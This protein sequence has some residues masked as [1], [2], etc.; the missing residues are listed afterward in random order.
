M[1]MTVTTGGRALTTA[2]ALFVLFSVSNSAMDDRAAPALGL[3]R[4]DGSIVQLADYRGK[5]V[6]VDFWASWCVPCKA[7]FPALD[8]LYQ[9][10]RDRGLEV[11]AVNVDEQRKAADAFLA[12]RPHLMPVLFDPKGE[13][14]QAFKIQGMP[15]SILIDRSGHIRFTHMGYSAK[16]FD[17]YLQEINQ[18]LL[19]KRR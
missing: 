12:A 5:V 2:V 19:E 1:W 3:H 10:E 9:R 15:S 14:A 17:S 8:A 6:L 13:A 11:M 18:L 16:V 7:S 4:A